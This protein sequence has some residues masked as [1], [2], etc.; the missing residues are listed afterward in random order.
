M[1]SVDLHAVTGEDVSRA[2]EADFEFLKTLTFSIEA[3]AR[4]GSS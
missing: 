1:L 2:E 3:S 4:C